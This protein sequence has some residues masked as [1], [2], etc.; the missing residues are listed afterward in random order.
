MEKGNNISAHLPCD[1]HSVEDVPQNDTDHHFVP[2]V[3][4]HSL[5]IILLLLDKGW[6]GC[7]S[8]LQRPSNLLCLTLGTDSSAYKQRKR[9]FFCLL[10]GINGNKESGLVNDDDDD[11]DD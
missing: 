1:G 11:D 6:R 5:P 10:C 3:E 4:Y 2:Q 7:C 8:C 9:I